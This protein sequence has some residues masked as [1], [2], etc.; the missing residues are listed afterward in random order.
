MTWDT[1]ADLDNHNEQIYRGQLNAGKATLNADE[2]L[3]NAAWGHVKAAKVELDAAR[4][5]KVEAGAE[6]SKYKNELASSISPPDPLRADNAERKLAQARVAFEGAN[7]RITLAINAY[8]NQNRTQPIRIWK[9]PGNART[10]H[11]AQ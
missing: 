5:A 10:P 11:L 1:I 8:K 4:Q 3:S 9:L 6:V 7:F 2:A